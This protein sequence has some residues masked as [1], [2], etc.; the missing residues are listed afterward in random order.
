MA[1]VRTFLPG[2]TINPDSEIEQMIRST[3]GVVGERLAWPRA[4]KGPAPHPLTKGGTLRPGEPFSR[5]HKKG[6][7]CEDQGQFP[8]RGE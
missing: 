3:G 2:S 6:A 1:S 4:L 8:R 5:G 7:S